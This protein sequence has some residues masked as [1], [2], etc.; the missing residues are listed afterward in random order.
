[1]IY[2]SESEI[3]SEDEGAQGN[4]QPKRPLKSALKGSNNAARL[5]PDGNY[6]MELLEGVGAHGLSCEH[7]YSL[8]DFVIRSNFDRS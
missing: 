6:P 2:G 5:R 3:D 1:V 4:D 7:C 8:H